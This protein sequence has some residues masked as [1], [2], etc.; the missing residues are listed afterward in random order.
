RAGPKRRL[1]S[2]SA[3]ER[4]GV[5]R[6]HGSAM[7]ITLITGPASSDRAGV[8]MDAMRGHLARGRE[9]L[10]IVPASGEADHCRRELAEEGAVLGVR[11]ERFEWLMGEA[12]RRA[13]VGRPT[14]SAIAREQA[15]AAILARCGLPPGAGAGSDPDAAAP[16]ARKPTPEGAPEPTPGYTRA[17]AAFLAELQV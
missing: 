16:V 15:L 5:V 6:H 8:V 17:L 1:E 7:P 13:G 9:P 12:A 14:L 11:V 2:R 4:V 10:L 3:R